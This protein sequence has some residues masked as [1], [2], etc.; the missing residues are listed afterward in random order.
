MLIFIF[1]SQNY[2]KIIAPCYLFYPMR[3]CLLCAL[4]CLVKALKLC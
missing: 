3:S 1:E 4:G 2:T